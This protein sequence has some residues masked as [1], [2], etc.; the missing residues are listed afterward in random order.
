M[1]AKVR[2]LRNPFRV[3]GII[4]L[5]V[6]GTGSIQADQA[7][8]T[9]LELPG[10]S[11]SSLRPE[12]VRLIND[13]FGRL[14]AVAKKRVDPGDGYET[15]PLSTRTTFTA[16]THALLM[17]KLTADSGESLSDSA[18][19]LIDRVDD[20]AGQIL[21]SR[22]D[23][24]YRVYVQMKPGALDRLTRSKEFYRSADNTVYHKGYPLCF[25]SARGA[26]S[27]QLSLTEDG[28]RADI[29]VDYRSPKFPVSLV[30]GHFSASNS[31]IRAG[32][33]DAK[34]NQQWSGMQNWWRNLLGLPTAENYRVS[35]ASER[36]VAPEPRRKGGAPA[37]AVYD[38]LNGWLVEQK[39]EDAIASFA[40]QSSACLDLEAQAPAE[41]AM[42][43]FLLLQRMMAVNVEIGKMSSLSDIIGA[44]A[45]TSDRLKVIKQPHESAFVLYDVRE[46]LA[47]EFK[48]VNP[49]DTGGL[50]AKALTSH[51]F[52]KYVGAVF[53]ITATPQTAARLVA[54][55]WQQEGGYWKLI[56]YT[57]DPEVDR[58]GVPD[59][60]APLAVAAPIGYVTGE[61]DMV[62]AASDFLR[63]WLV[64]KN[65]EKALGSVAAESLACVALYHPDDVQ[66]PAT[67]EEARELLRKGMA[68][69]AE[70]IG[71]VRRLGEAIVAP[72][73]HHP[74]VKL[75]RHK[76]DPAFVIAAIPESMAVAAACDRRRP[77][78]DPDFSH[79]DAT[80]YGR[81]YATGFSIASGSV[82]PATLWT[83]WRNMNG[84]W[85][86]V[87]YTLL[88]P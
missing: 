79:A 24:Q 14:S 17:T 1:T 41:R 38:F 47:E 6:I 36:V 9:T 88:T 29:D 59:L 11:Y 46:D 75:V 81:Y 15:L 68:R 16:V 71:P 53:R 84:A 28:S 49:L 73:V 2:G 37:D 26:P 74:A 45:V 57:V 12:Q 19:E 80:G 52:G 83:V 7:P 54:T 30:N 42:R 34:H 64:K 27:I 51:A 21:G 85:K 22:G 76:E 13:W 82:D 61:Q 55:V 20:V 86:I 35:T 63:D 56:A 18:I 39:P 65:I 23:R 72:D 5:I 70:V 40:E 50:S 32:D 4:T 48:C 69:T 10:S 33:N 67:R 31:D 3:L 66:A 44:A 78:G 77:D 60:R 62:K 8:A 43:K 25:R 87:S 58:S